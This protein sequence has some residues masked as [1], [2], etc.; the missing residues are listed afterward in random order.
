MRRVK[1][2]VV[3]GLEMACRATRAVGWLPGWHRVYP[4]C[5]FARWSSALDYRW[6]T[7]RWPV[8]DEDG[9]SAWVDW[10]ESLTDRARGAGHWHHW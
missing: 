8:H 5:L 6:A 7:R 9:D 1:V 3:D 2:L 4:Q 10:H